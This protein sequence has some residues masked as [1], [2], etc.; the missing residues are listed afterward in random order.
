MREVFFLFL[1]IRPRQRV[2]ANNQLFS[3]LSFLFSSPFSLTT[4][5][6]NAKN[7]CY[8]AFDTQLH[9][10]NLTDD[11]TPHLLSIMC[12]RFEFYVNRRQISIYVARIE[13]IW[14]NNEIFLCFRYIYIYWSSSH[15]IIRSN[16]LVEKLCSKSDIHTDTICKFNL[17]I[18]SN[19][20]FFDR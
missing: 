12:L 20:C 9:F 14:R 13:R 1:H 10:F 2:N 19:H 7:S 18:I 17:N 16:R 5:T 3:S 4:T 11:I 15:L 8:F 6:N